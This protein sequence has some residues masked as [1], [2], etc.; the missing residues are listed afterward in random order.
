M[1]VML[2]LLIMLAVF[3]SDEAYKLNNFNIFVFKIPMSQGQATMLE[4]HIH[5]RFN[6]L[7]KLGSGAYGHVWKVE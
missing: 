6:V 2:S 1:I 7:K 3:S 4:S 5:S